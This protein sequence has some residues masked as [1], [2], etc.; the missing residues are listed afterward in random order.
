M[1]KI[2]HILLKIESKK[3]YFDITVIKF[4]P[5]TDPNTL[6][7]NGPHTSARLAIILMHHH[8]L[9]FSTLHQTRSSPMIYLKSIS[10]FKSIAMTFR[11]A[12]RVHRRDP[13]GHLTIQ[14]PLS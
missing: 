12:M 10:M 3:Q 6:N 2:D 8:Y 1:N 11:R 14:C 7:Q 13:H 4:L 5:S 9:T